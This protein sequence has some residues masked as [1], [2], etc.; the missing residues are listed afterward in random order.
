VLREAGALAW[1]ATHVQA[2]AHTVTCTAMAKPCQ[3][4]AYELV[5]IDPH[6]RSPKRVLGVMACSHRHCGRWLCH[7]VRR[8]PRPQWTAP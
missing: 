5:R 3:Q 4:T 6:K 8:Q 7:H 2:S 1:L